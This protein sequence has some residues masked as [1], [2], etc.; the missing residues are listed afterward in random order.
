MYSKFHFC[1]I[2]ISHI[3]VVYI[4]YFSIV[5]GFSI[6]IKNDTGVHLRIDSFED[7]CGNIYIKE[8]SPVFIVPGDSIQFKNVVP[9]IHH[10]KM[11]ANGTCEGSALAISYEQ[12][13]YTLQ[14]ILKGS[15]LCVIQKPLIWP[16]IIRCFKIQNSIWIHLLQGCISNLISLCRIIK[17]LIYQ[18]DLANI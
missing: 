15:C 5:F 3:F 1:G 6:I 9:T 13:S 8:M 2:V 14:A 10:Y 4:S 11:C 16:G 18:T 17:L 12:K 7:N